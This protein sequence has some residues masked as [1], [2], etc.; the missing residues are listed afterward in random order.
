MTKVLATTTMRTNSMNG[1][2]CSVHTLALEYA[3]EVL[4]QKAADTINNREVLNDGCQQSA[5]LIP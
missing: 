1:A 5:L 2:G 3:N 4:A